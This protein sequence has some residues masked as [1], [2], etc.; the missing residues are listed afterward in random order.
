MD[1]KKGIIDFLVKNWWIIAIIFFIC[2]L[3]GPILLLSS[4]LSFF[5]LV[6]TDINVASNINNLT[7]P[8]IG[9]FSVIFLFLAFKSQH[10]FNAK[11]HNFNVQQSMIINYQILKDN[12]KQILESHMDFKYQN[13]DYTI[14]EVIE[15]LDLFSDEHNELKK[16]GINIDEKINHLSEHRIVYFTFSTVQFYL[17]FTKHFNIIEGHIDDIINSNIKD[18]YKQILLSD[19]EDLISIV[20]DLKPIQS[21]SDFYV[22]INKSIKNIE[23]LKFNIDEFNKIYYS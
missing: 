7:T 8:I 11:Q 23:I 17:E 10:D 1:K 16:N 5:S 14:C 6:D 15:E 20:E 21:E 2:L 18:Y 19:F 4:G 3:F 22:N 12:H 13:T 9:F